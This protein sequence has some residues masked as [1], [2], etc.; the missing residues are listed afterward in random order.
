VSREVWESVKTAIEQEIG[1]IHQIAQR[2]NPD[3]PAKELNHFISDYLMSQSDD[4]PSEIALKII[5]D[6]ARRV[7]SYGAI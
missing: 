2:L 5:H 7:L 1:M 6:E 3:A 4:L